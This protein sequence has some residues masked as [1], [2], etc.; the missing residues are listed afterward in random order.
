[1]TAFDLM[2]YMRA[3][4]H[5]NHVATVLC[6][7]AAQLQPEKLAQLVEK[8]DVEITA[9][10]RLGYLLDTLKLS[11]NLQPLEQALKAKKPIQRLLVAGIDQPIFEHNKRW[12]ILVNEPVEPDEL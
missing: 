2:R 5:I 4:G 12:H 7:L 3:S 1:M 11:I 8:E 10:Q 6:E 9:A